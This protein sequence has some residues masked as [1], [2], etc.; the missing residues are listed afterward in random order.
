M[1]HPSPRLREEKGYTVNH[2]NILS[3]R[4]F[5][6]KVPVKF[7][8]RE[9][10]AV[11]SGKHIDIVADLAYAAVTEGHAALVSAEGGIQSIL[12]RGTEDNILFSESIQSCLQA[13]NTLLNV[14]FFP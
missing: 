7:E 10:N 9:T 12:K 5:Q 4:L 2:Q 8:E 14:Y 3:I 1:V 13:V 11:T 6:Y